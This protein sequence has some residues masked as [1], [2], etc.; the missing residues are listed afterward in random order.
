MKLYLDADIFLALIKE[1]DRLKDLAIGFFEKYK[2]HE[3]TTSTLTCMEIWFYLHKNNLKE[4]VLDSVR[5]ITSIC[6][7][8]DW[9]L[10]DLENSIVLSEHHK[11]TPADSVHATLAMKCDCIVSSD[12]SFDRVPGL[13]RTDFS[14]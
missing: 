14:R 11:L 12:S 7:I 4:K 9:D 5:A 1:R 8:L 2:T 6:A 3:L 10:Y 13:K